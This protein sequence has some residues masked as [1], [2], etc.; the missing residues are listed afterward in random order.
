M[1]NKVLIL[2]LLLVVAILF[3]SCN[4]QPTVTHTQP[5][6]PMGGSTT[7]KPTIFRH[8]DNDNNGI[9]DNCG[10]TFVDSRCMGAKC[11]EDGEHVWGEYKSNE[12]VHW[13]EYICGHDWPDIAEE[14]MDT[15]EN[16]ICD[17][18]GSEI[19]VPLYNNSALALSSEKVNANYSHLRDPDFVT[20]LEKIEVFSAKLSEKVYGEGGE[21]ANICISPIS[22]YMALALT[23]E[24]A[25]NETRQE[26]LDAVGVTYD[27]V[28]EYTKYLYAF[29][30]QEFYS[31]DENGERKLTSYELLTNSIWLANWMPYKDEGVQKLANGYNCDVFQVD[32]TSAEGKE[33]IKSYIEDKTRGLINGDLELKPETAF[34]LLN[35]FYLKDA[36]TDIGKDLDMTEE[37]YS[38]H[39]SDKSI[40]EKE[41]LMGQY[42]PG[43]IYEAENY[44]A[45]YTST[46]NGLKLYF[47]LP[48]DESTLSEVFITQNISDLLS[49][50]DWSHVDQAN[51]QLHFTRTL[52]PEFEAEFDG[53]LKDILE[54]DFGITTLFG[55]ECEMGNVTDTEVFCSD[56]IHKAKLKADKSGIEGAAITAVIMDAES[57]DP[58]PVYENVFHD[59]IVDGAFGFI[60]CDQSGAV[61]FSGV[62][63]TVEE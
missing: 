5:D 53:S 59:F 21:G 28:R 24:C 10:G 3:N 26:I 35:T 39:N 20:F 12:Y 58:T 52:F 15:D 60:L 18:C 43:K 8:D 2:T 19:S 9:C 63:N 14:H 41:L 6:N 54:G 47:M 44:T 22:V 50:Q 13:R 61:L 48:D 45:M 7:V 46:V 11:A 37:K 25:E 33:A 38:F 31:Y 32:F 36:W 49:L 17:I 55:F 42:I 30:N 57:A 27:E 51:K 40:V 1:K 16:G 4:L 29:C 56:I 62:I 23:C 34:V